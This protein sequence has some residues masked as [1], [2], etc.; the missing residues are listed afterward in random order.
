MGNNEN[1]LTVTEVAEILGVSRKEVLGY[2][3]RGD[4]MAYV[5]GKRAHRI[6]RKALEDFKKRR[7]V[8]PV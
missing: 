3:K 8:L 1:D 4:L 7:R 6:E 2:I 5:P